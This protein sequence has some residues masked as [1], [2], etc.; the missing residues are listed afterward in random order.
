VREADFFVGKMGEQERRAFGDKEPF[1]FYLSAFLSAAVDDWNVEVHESGSG[2]DLK[3]EAIKVG[4]SYS[5]ESGT[6]EV[7]APPGTLPAVI[8]KPAYSFT[9]SGPRFM[10]PL[11]DG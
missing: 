1:D 8:Y 9:I 11:Q 6:L 3:S 4:H 7:S 10:M 5:D 2:R